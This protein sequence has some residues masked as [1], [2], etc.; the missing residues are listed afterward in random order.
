MCPQCF[1]GFVEELPENSNNGSNQN[2]EEQDDS[3]FRSVFNDFS[4]GHFQMP[5][6]NNNTPYFRIANEI[7]GPIITGS[8]GLASTSRYN[9]NIFCLIT[10]VIHCVCFDLSTNAEPSDG[11]SSSNGSNPAHLG[12]RRGQR[13]QGPINFE[14]ILQE[15]LVSI[16]DG[17]TSGRVP[18][19][20][21]GNPGMRR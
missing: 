2:S 6:G 19:F 9:N 10:Q 15:I 14:D 11:S 1:D 3:Q 5:T 12:R 16:T 13:L 18:M 21:M 8:P 4:M 17:A 7:L 20:F